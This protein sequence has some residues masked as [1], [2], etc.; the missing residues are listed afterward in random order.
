M[1]FDV[2]GNCLVIDFD[3]GEKISIFIWDIFEFIF[4][5]GKGGKREIVYF[6]ND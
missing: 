4:Y 5:I 3:I 1:V 6:G 2:V